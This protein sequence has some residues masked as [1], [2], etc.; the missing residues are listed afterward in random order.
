MSEAIETP[1]SETPEPADKPEPTDHVKLA[2]KDRDAAKKRA[3]EAEASRDEL[4]AKLAE[5]EAERESREVEQ[6]RKKNDFAALEKRLA[7]ERDDA[8]K[9]A[10]DAKA[11]IAAR[12]RADREAALVDTVLPK[13]GSVPKL[14]AEGLIQSLAKRGKFDPAPESI[15]DHY[16][17]DVAK[18]VREALGDLYPTRNGGS[19]G[20][21]GVNLAIKPPSEQPDADP[22]KAR[23]A[24]LQKRRSRR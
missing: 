2:F 4:R 14:V 21:P 15:D 13:L 20:S 1:P 12:T 17:A 23:L 5:H 9:E 10:A 11:L 6:E 24:E 22:V 8:R 16:A 19:P 3:R 18:H 7:K